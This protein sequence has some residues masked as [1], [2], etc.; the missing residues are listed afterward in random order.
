MDPTKPDDNTPAAA[1]AA[2]TPAAEAAPATPASE[3]DDFAAAF[4]EL[5]A[6]GEVPAAGKPAPA[7]PA[8]PATPAS[9]GA[10]PTPEATPSATPSTDAAT[11]PVAEPGTAP[12]PAP[13]PAAEPNPLEKQIAELQSQLAA[14]QEAARTPPAPATPDTPTAPKP[15]YTTEEQ[16]ALEKYWQ[17]WPDVAAGEQ[18]QRKA[19][20]VALCNHIFSQI[21]PLIAQLQE[22][23]PALESSTQYRD[24]V[25]T[26]PDYEQVREPVIEW[27]GKQPEWVRGAYERVTNEGTPTE[28][29]QLVA[30]FKKD[31]GWVAPAAAPA[32]TTAAAAPAATTPAAVPAA[33]APK[34]AALP[35]AAAA[36][37]ASLKPVKVGRTEPTTAQDPNDFDSAWNEFAKAS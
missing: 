7:A 37:A 24:L 12:T 6:P 10:T 9:A 20:Y 13:A 27:V 8:A 5:N 19:E 2:P 32:A 4:A 33:A 22:R 3:T 17:D 30:Q 11:P 25:E 16:T 14:L 29:A 18:L 26:I 21:T 28:I 36:A 35:A 31:T 1:P 23:L 15:V 34:P